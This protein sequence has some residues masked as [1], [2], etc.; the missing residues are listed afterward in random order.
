V[1]TLTPPIVIKADGLAAG[2]G[3]VIAESYQAA[4]DAL[5]AI[6]KQKVFGAAGNKIVIE[7]FLRGEEAS[8]LA[9]TDGKEF[10]MLPAAQDHKRIFDGDTG[11]NTGGMGAYAPAPVVTPEIAEQI[12]QQIL[13]PTLEGMRSEGRLYRGCLYVG[14][15]I[16]EKGPFVIEYNSRF[17]NPETEVVLPLIEDDL[18]KIFFDIA[19]GSLTTS[20]LHLKNAASVCVVMASKGYPDAYESGKVITGL[21]SA[22]ASGVMVFHAATKAQNDSIVTAGGRV[23]AVT[24]LGDSSDLEAAIEKS[25]EAVHKI[26]FEGAQFRT[27]IGKKGL[28][29][30]QG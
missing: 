16:T 5:D 24:A 19:R 18:A 8:I 10:V 1:K 27:D 14:L 7:E 26:S 3:V 17:G 23:L 6:M 21:Q 25:Y 29:P 20:T 12:A 4:S 11:K 22:E 9:L 15:M 30:A 2:K 28:T 13:R